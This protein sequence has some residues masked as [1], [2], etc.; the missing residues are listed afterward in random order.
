MSKCHPGETTA[1]GVIKRLRILFR[2]YG[3]PREL[4]TDGGPPFP[5][6][7]LQTFLKAWGVTFRQSSSYY[8]QSNGRAELAVKVGKRI[9]YDNVGPD[10]S[11]N[12]DHIARALL[13]HRNTPLR[14]IVLSP[15]QMVYGRNLRDCLPVL[16]EAH[17]IHPEWRLVADDRERALAKRNI[18]NTEK[19]NEHT[20]LLPELEVGD[21]VSVQNQTGPRPKRWE[22]TAIIVEK[23]ENRQY[24]VRMDGSGR[25]SLRNRRFLRR[26]LPVCSDKPLRTPQLK[27]TRPIQPVQP[28]QLPPQ[29]IIA[30]STSSNLPQPVRQAISPALTPGNLPLQTPQRGSPGAENLRPMQLNFVDM[31]MPS[32]SSSPTGEIPVVNNKS[33][34]VP[35]APVVQNP[36]APVRRSTRET[37]PKRD[38]S[39][40]PTG[41]AH[42]YYSTSST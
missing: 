23:A 34:S 12:T 14:D 1:A 28:S 26:I 11:L 30:P 3:A 35:T 20:K 36:D 38:L 21:H 33:A 15:A 2:A 22:K 16:A 4:A 29:Y 18:L 32:P 13:K 5:S 24:I 39:P 7:E 41:Q 6:N 10:G 25:C 9:V 19:Y 40:C 37:K 8:A 27:V 31:D 17:K 42:K